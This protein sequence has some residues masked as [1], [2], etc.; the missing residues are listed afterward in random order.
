MAKI[1]SFNLL[2]IDI[3]YIRL[4][5]GLATG[6]A[7]KYFEPVFPCM[8]INQHLPPADACLPHPLVKR[9]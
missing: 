7:K 8:L 6:T 5:D 1:R 9:L 2:C 3:K 4:I